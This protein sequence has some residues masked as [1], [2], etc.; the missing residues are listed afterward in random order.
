MIQPILAVFT[1]IKPQHL[2]EIKSMAPGYQVLMQDELTPAD[3]PH[4]EITYG[5]NLRML[6][7]T[8]WSKMESL[9]WIQ[10]ASAGIDYLPETFRKDSALQ[11]STMSG[12]HAQPITE[13][14]FAY[15]LATGRQLFTSYVQQQKAIWGKPEHH[16][17]FSLKDKTLLIYGTGNIGQEMARIGL[18]FGMS[19]VGVNTSGRE[20]EPFTQTVTLEDSGEKVSEADFIVSSLPATL[21]TENYFDEVW[22]DLLKPTAHF[23]NIGRGN[24]VDENA[25]YRALIAEKFAGA[26]LDVFKEEPLP[27][28]SP[29]WRLPN[30][31]ITPHI[32]G[33]IEHFALDAY[34]IFLE[35]LKSYL[36]TG[37]ICRNVYSK[38][39]G[40]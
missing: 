3:F 33:H 27:G 29:L 30:L 22:F 31:V 23:I 25:L 8:E 13:S 20:I 19:I 36:N 24:T 9:R 18:A 2:E 1:K 28:D 40:Y 11:I 26:Y 34:P 32:T 7:E 6:S 15:L 35:N 17:F 38:E 4:I 39:K 12:L 5:W 37:R 21:K 10:A 14:V 16:T